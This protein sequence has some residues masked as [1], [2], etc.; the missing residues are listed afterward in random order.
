MNQ[1][2]APSDPPK[3]ELRSDVDHGILT[4]PN[5]LTVV[6]LIIAIVFPFLPTSWYLP[7]ILVAGLTDLLDGALARYFNSRSAA[8]KVLDPIADK[9]FLIG[10][11]ITLVSGGVLTV[12]EVLLIGMRDVS[13]FVGTVAGLATRRWHAFRQME[14]TLLGKVTTAALF[15]Y[16]VILVAIPD[17]A[18]PALIMTATLSGLAAAHYA[19]LFVTMARLEPRSDRAL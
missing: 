7:A 15:A 1:T 4:F 14:P 19:W 12:G 17:Y 9:A 2:T 11:V 3:D 18:E 6:R 8:G 13:V 10:V 5:L 16:F